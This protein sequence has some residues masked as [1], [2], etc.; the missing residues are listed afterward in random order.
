MKIRKWIQI[1]HLILFNQN[2]LKQMYKEIRKMSQ[3]MDNL[4]A[5]AVVLQT[6]VDSV[7][8][9]IEELR[10][11]QGEN[12]DTRIDAVTAIVDGEINRLNAAIVP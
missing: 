1:F 10:Q 4:E 6:T 7:L 12:L 9:K 11:G 2:Q 8:V 5:K 3:A